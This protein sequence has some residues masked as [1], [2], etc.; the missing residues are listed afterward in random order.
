M[1]R[2]ICEY[3]VIQNIHQ[4][5]GS[6]SLL[7]ILIC[8][9][10]SVYE[11][12]NNKQLGSLAVALNTYLYPLTLI[13]VHEWKSFNS[14]QRVKSPETKQFQPQMSMVPLM[15]Y[16]RP[17]KHF[18]IEIPNFWAWADKLSREILGHLRYFPPNYQHPFWYSE[19]L[20]HTMRKSLLNWC[21][22]VSISKNV[23]FYASLV[24]RV[25]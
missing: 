14:N 22:L 3:F 1:K 13:F 15:D 16:G 20:V 6:D 24:V 12:S 25:Y 8:Y 4:E 10:A 2:T 19:F 23:V 18:T 11:A 7:H 9:I 5:T 21:Y 17:M